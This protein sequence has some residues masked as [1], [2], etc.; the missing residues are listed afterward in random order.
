MSGASATSDRGNRRQLSVRRFPCCGARA[1]RPARHRRWSSRRRRT[2]ARTRWRS[3]P[4]PARP[5]R[6]RSPLAHHDGPGP[7][8][9]QEPTSPPAASRDPG[10]RAHSP[11][12]SDAWSPG[13][14]TNASAGA[15]TGA[16]LSVGR[17]LGQHRGRGRG[18]P[19][20]GRR[21]GGHRLLPT[22]A[23]GTRRRARRR[24]RRVLGVRV[25]AD[26]PVPT[27]RRRSCADQ[28]DARRAI[29]RGPT[30]AR[31]DALDEA[32]EA[33]AAAPPTVSARAG[34]IRASSSARVSRTAVLHAGQRHRDRRS[35]CRSVRASLASTQ[36]RRS[37]A[38]PPATLRVGR[39]RARRP[40]SRDAAAA[41][42]ANTA[43]SKSMPPRLLDALRVPSSSKPAS[44]SCAAPRRRRCR[45]RGRRRRSLRRWPTALGVRVAARPPPRARSGCRPSP[46][47]AS[48]TA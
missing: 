12:A 26:R 41:T 29:D 6:L 46:T 8:R 36:S 32:R 27:P 42:W 43:S 16:A 15:S 7:A 10:A 48:R 11:P 34:R 2:P 45:R 31:S 25:E 23:G 4:R 22:A 5:R 3:S 14:A 21:G 17:H 19:V 24:G 39:G 37:R 20:D 33:P 1:G 40:A 44:P 9:A 38:M 47:S 35:R 13:A 18:R 28:R 30:A